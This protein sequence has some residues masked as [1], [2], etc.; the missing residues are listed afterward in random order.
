[1]KILNVGAGI[2]SPFAVLPTSSSAS[3]ETLQFTLG[4][5][6]YRPLLHA[7]K[8]VRRTTAHLAVICGPGVH[9]ATGCLQRLVRDIAGQALIFCLIDHFFGHDL[10]LYV[11]K[12]PAYFGNRAQP[13]VHPGA[14]ATAFS[15]RVPQDW[16]FRSSGSAWR[17]HALLKPMAS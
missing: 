3:S 11:V 16:G 15:K 4:E 10:H 17:Q 13:Y 9:A 12:R 2:D 5:L 6:W 8:S 7:S 1:M 14:A